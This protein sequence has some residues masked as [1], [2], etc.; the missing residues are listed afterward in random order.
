MTFVV[1]IV[2]NGAIGGLLK[3]RCLELNIDFNVF[4]RR[5]EKEPLTIELLNGE[6]Q[7]FTQ[8]SQVVSKHSLGDLLFIPVKAYQVKSVID[9]VKLKL[10]Q[11]TCLVLLH[12]GMGSE[13]LIQKE[14]PGQP[15]ILATTSHAAYKTSHYNVKQT[16][17]G[18]SQYGWLNKGQLDLGKQHTIEQLA[19]QVLQPSTL[20]KDMQAALW[21]KLA[22]NA[23]INPLT[24]V[25]RVKNGQLREIQYQ[26][27]IT[28]ICQEVSL[29][30]AQHGQFL[31]TDELIENTYQVIEDTTDN[32][33]SMHQDIGAYRKTEIDSIS[34]YLIQKAAEVGQPVPENEKWFNKIKVL[35]KAY[36]H[37]NL[38]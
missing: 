33:S 38:P 13:E 27:T 25:L 35:E 36:T 17:I 3:A 4:A 22:V 20:M 16:G 7:Q 9:E 37:I 12:N 15:V 18:Q 14:L 32:Y 8:C 23:A 1:S 21:K 30:A 6:K 10:T 24:A 29:T 34:G 5:E 2:G 19:G 31:N 26:K 28:K 11:E